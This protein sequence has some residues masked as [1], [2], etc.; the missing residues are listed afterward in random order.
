MFFVIVLAPG[1][2]R[3]SR[4]T[5]QIKYA[6][7]AAV[8]EVQRASADDDRLICLLAL[9]VRVVYL[10]WLDTTTSSHDVEC[11]VRSREAMFYY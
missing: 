4:G 9:H 11:P 1:L 7:E 8:C 6:V 3:R 2:N 10:Y 5:P